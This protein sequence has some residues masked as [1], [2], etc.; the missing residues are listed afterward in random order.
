MLKLD[1]ILQIMNQNAIP[2]IN[3][4]Q[5]E[6]NEKFIGIMKNELGGKIMTKSFG[7][8]GKY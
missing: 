3:C 1:L 6:Y 2:Q 7:L 8:R 5:K 4:Y